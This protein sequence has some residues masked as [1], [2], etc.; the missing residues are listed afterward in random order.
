M[1]ATCSATCAKMVGS[2]G[3]KGTTLDE[4]D[5]TEEGEDDEGDDVERR[6]VDVC[7]RLITT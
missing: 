7:R 5:N 4:G 1:D 2:L 6:V 3:S